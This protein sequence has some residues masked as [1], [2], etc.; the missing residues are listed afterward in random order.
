MC[1]V[2]VR[3][4]PVID[5][6]DLYG[7]LVADDEFV[8]A[9]GHRAVPLEPGDPALH[10]VPLLVDLRIERVLTALSNVRA[11][12]NRARASG[13]FPM[14]PPRTLHARWC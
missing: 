10:R 6:R 9:R 8:E 3:S 1:S 11:E 14:A 2:E 4:E 13:I 7:G 12:G 5:G